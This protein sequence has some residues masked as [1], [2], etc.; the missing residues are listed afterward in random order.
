MNMQNRSGLSTEAWGTPYLTSP[1]EDDL[2]LEKR[3]VSCLLDKNERKV[4]D[5]ESLT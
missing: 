2:F 4:S 5:E 1:F 3:I